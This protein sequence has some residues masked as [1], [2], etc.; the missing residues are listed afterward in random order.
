MTVTVAGP[1]A[2]VAAAVKV[3]TVLLPVVE[4][5]L[6]VAVTPAEAPSP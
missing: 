5:G 2:A 6:N 3:T 1:R 4:T